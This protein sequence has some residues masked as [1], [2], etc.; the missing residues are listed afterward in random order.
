MT[1]EK[2]RE[3]NNLRIGKIFFICLTVLATTANASGTSHSQLMRNSVLESVELNKNVMSVNNPNKFSMGNKKEL[4]DK[5]ITEKS[6]ELEG[7][8]LAMMLEP[9][10]PDGKESNLYGGGNSS[11]IF[12]SM[13][14]QEYGKTLANS[15]GVGLTK[16]IEKQLRQ[17]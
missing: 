10:F 12:R 11:G 7:V 6:K 3:I 2:L 17:Q 16:G 4:T 1:N 9:M 14:I 13:M 8:F 15:G 5:Q